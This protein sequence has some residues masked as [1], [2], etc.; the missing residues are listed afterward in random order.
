MSAQ[1]KNSFLSDSSG[2]LSD[3][4]SLFYDDVKQLLQFFSYYVSANLTQEKHNFR[5]FYF[6]HIYIIYLTV[7]VMW[8][9]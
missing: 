4:F 2:A 8:R 5:Q 3:R 9:F 6:F 1:I 7:N